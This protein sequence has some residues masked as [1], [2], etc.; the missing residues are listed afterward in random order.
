VKPTRVRKF[1]PATHCRERTRIVS[2]IAVLLYLQAFELDVVRA[3][4]CLTGRTL[5]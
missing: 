3:K 2:A 4:A 5:I 1:E